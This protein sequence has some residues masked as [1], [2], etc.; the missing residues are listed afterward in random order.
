MEE[1]WKDVIGYEG[2]Y[3]ISNNGNVMSLNYHGLGYQR[4]IRQSTSCYGYKVVGL[5]K[6][7]HSSQKFVHRLVAEAFIPNPFGF[8]QVNHRDEVKINNNV[9][10]L[11]WCTNRYNVNYGTARE[12]MIK[13]KKKNIVL[14]YDLSCNLLQTYESIA[15]AARCTGLCRAHISACY[16]GKN[17]T[18]G[19]F[20][21]RPIGFP[22]KPGDEVQNKRNR[23]RFNFAQDSSPKLF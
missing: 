6:N 14:Q 15:E 10:N 19:G 9:D 22:P 18:H 17:R 16:R 7:G 2:L 13:K 3:L 23:G 20:F 1:I 12:R 21:W 5:S 11:E 8:P 4:I